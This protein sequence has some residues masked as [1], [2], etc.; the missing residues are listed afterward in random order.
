ME[1]GF[2]LVEDIQGGASRRVD[3][4]GLK[5]GMGMMRR[6]TMGASAFG[7]QVKTAGI[8]NDYRL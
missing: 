6:G 1:R 5:G 4:E 3:I 2:Q 8:R 7:L